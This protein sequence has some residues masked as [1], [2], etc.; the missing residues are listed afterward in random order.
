[1]ASGTYAR[2]IER[3]HITQ[4]ERRGNLRE[5]FVRIHDF[6]G[7]EDA[8]WCVQAAGKPHKFVQVAEGSGNDRIE[9]LSARSGLPRCHGFDA[10]QTEFVYRG[11]QERRLFVMTFDQ[12][13]RM[14]RSREG[15]QNSGKT[16]ATPGHAS[17]A[18]TRTSY[19]AP[20][21]IVDGERA[22]ACRR[23]EI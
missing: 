18:H 9:G 11:S 20:E 22:V 23:G 4:I 21:I 2:D 15:E 10:G 14:L 7:G 5:F 3:D 13:H 17:R 1:M 19:S 8:V 6:H 16:R 12:R